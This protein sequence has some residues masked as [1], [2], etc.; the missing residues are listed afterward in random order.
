MKSRLNHLFVFCSVLVTLSAC[1]LGLTLGTRSM[2]EILPLVT[3]PGAPLPVD[4]E[5][6]LGLALASPELDIGSES[7]LVTFVSVRVLTLQILNSSELDDANEDGDLDNFDFLTGAQIFIRGN[8]NGTTNQLLIASLPEDDPQIGSSAR[9]L[10]L[11]V[12]D[13]N[14]VFDFLLLPDGYEILLDL[15]GAV[16]PDNVT[17]S[18]ELVYRIGLGV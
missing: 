14:D 3:V 7:A 6:S 10:E 4:L 16:P 11:T 17:L 1:N 8:F 5:F 18:G 15:D 2:T 9:T 13:N 12:N